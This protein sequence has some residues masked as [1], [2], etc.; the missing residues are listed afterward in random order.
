MMMVRR[1]VMKRQVQNEVSEKMM[2]NGT[3]KYNLIKY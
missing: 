2:T 1:G 3:A